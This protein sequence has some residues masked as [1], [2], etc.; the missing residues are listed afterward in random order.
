MASDNTEKNGA[1]SDRPPT[2]ETNG[3]ELHID[4]EDLDENADHD[5]NLNETYVIDTAKKTFPQK[6]VHVKRPEPDTKSLVD[7]N[8]DHN[9]PIANEN[10]N[11][12]DDVTD[13]SVFPQKPVVVNRLTNN[14]KCDQ[15]GMLFTN[16]ESLRQHKQKFCLGVEETGIKKYLNS[17]P[18]PQE[19]M[20]INSHHND[21]VQ[22]NGSL[23]TT[24]NNSIFNKSRNDDLDFNNSTND[25]KLNP[26]QAQSAINELKS[27]KNKKSMEQSLR[28]MED[29]L[30]RDTIRDKKLTTSSSKTPLNLMT[31][32][33]QYNIR[34]SGT[35]L[36]SFNKYIKSP[37]N[38]DDPFK[39]LVKEVSH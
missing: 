26:Y 8:V 15:C 13:R 10:D 3:K 11:L 37:Q 24:L 31:T 18:T 38:K 21:S 6:P 14:V 39:Y 35:S 29:T 27:Y 2:K 17:S 33:D 28:D 5:S 7:S 4:L 1:E 22:K 30:I 23:N 25:F 19:N 12:N 16:S 34:T 36:N 20:D 32:P 9:E